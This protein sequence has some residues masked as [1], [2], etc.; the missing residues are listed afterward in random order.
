MWEGGR[1]GVG[2]GQEKSKGREGKEGPARRHLL[3]QQARVCK[4]SHAPRSPAPCPVAEGLVR[5]GALHSGCKLEPER[6]KKS[7]H[8]PEAD[9]SPPK[10]S[11]G[12]TLKPLSPSECQGRGPLPQKPGQTKGPL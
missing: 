11:S 12:A 8:W 4:P 6:Y 10:Y 9:C 5:A 2:D 7:P 3:S 1:D